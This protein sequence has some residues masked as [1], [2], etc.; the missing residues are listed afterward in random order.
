HGAPPLLLLPPPLPEEGNGDGNQRHRHERGD[1]G[2]EG[3]LGN[4][5][6]LPSFVCRPSLPSALEK[7]RVDRSMPYDLSRSAKRGRMPVAL[8][9]PITLSPSI[10]CRSYTKMSCMVITSPSIPT[11][12]EMERIFR[13]PSLR[14]AACTTTLMA[15][16]ICCRIAFSGRFRLAIETIVSSRASASRGV[17]A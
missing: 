11:I 17:L 13:V 12:S 10:P 9:W 15:A 5:Y 1:G 6:H 14:R 2:K 16:A 4:V 3:A 7:S 8:N